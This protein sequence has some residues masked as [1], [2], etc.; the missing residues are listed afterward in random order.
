MDDFTSAYEVLYNTFE[1]EEETLA[2]NNHYDALSLNKNHEALLL[3]NERISTLQA[4][5]DD[6]S[7]IYTSRSKQSRSSRLS[8]SS[9][10]SS[11]SLQ[12]RAEMAT[13][14]ARL[15]TELK[16]HDV[17]S[18]KTATLKRQEDEVKKLQ[19]IKK[20]AA[21]K[22]ELDA[23]SKRVEDYE[24]VGHPKEKLLPNDDCRD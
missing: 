9:E 15:Q 21:T 7:L 17:E 16:F 19:M 6:Q 22:A 14:V 3:L 13:K 20:L 8:R 4:Q 5:R 23:I 24:D 11:L 2:L 18:K 1:I 12:R 10:E